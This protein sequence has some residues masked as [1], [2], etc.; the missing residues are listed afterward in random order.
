MSTATAPQTNA[1][2]RI[3]PAQ[4]VGNNFT[5]LR[6]Y[7]CGGVSNLQKMYPDAM[8]SAANRLAQAIV[9]EVAKSESLQKCTPLSLWSCAVQAAQL[10]IEIGGPL[11]QAYMVPRKGQACFQVGYRGMITLAQRSRRIAVI[12][13]VLVRKGDHFKVKQ[14]SDAGIEHEPANKSREWTH[15]YAIVKYRGGGEDFEVMTQ[16]EVFAHRDR[17]SQEWKSRGQASV[18]GQH[19]EPMAMKTLIHKLVKRCPIGVDLGPD[20]EVS[21]APAAAGAI[22]EATAPAAEQLEAGDDDGATDA[23]FEP[24]GESTQ[25]SLQI[26]DY[27]NDAA[28]MEALVESKGATYAGLLAHINKKCSAK[29]TKQ[30]AWAEIPAQQRKVGVEWLLA[31]PSVELA[32]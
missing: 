15:C 7:I 4:A 24:A 19:P 29:H 21:E 26:E 14:G 10:N 18:W 9:T 12:R 8:K 20:E 13:A 32:Q 28:H 25:E 3:D 11:G 22:A 2:A 27:L 17:F 31:M 16:E 6:Q 23:E 5:G 1:I 30:T